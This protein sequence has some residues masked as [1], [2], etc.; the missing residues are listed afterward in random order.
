MSDEEKVHD[1]DSSA[2]QFRQH[3]QSVTQWKKSYRHPVTQVVLL[4][5]VCF[6]TEG[7]FSGLTGLGA[8]GQAKS[9]TSANA[10]TVVYA[11]AMSIHPGAK[12]FVIAAGAILGICSALSWTAQG[13]LML[14]YPI[15]SQKGRELV[16]LPTD[17]VGQT[18]GRRTQSAGELMWVHRFHLSKSRMTEQPSTGRFSSPRMLRDVASRPHDKPEEN[19]LAGF[20][21]AIKTDP[22]IIILFPMFLASNWH[23]TWQMNDYNGARFDIQARSLNNLIYWVIQIC[24]STLFGWLLDVSIVRRRVRA[25][26]AWATLLAMVMGVHVWAYFYQKGY[27]RESVLLSKVG[28]QDSTYVASAFFYASCAFVGAAWQIISYWILGALSNNPDKLAYFT[29][30]HNSIQ[31]MGAAIAWRLD[32]LEV[33]FMTMLLSTWI[34]LIMGL[35]LAFPVVYWRI[36]DQTKSP[37][38]LVEPPATSRSES[39]QGDLSSQSTVCET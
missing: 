3:T 10:L 26:T 33:P 34:V 37:P 4:G 15:E 12:S 9:T 39:R 38:D 17:C 29:G 18:S 35:V 27:T 5:F 8:A 19:E 21:H 31:A 23:Y 7:S 20:V 28:I 16:N 25:L 6:L 14:A 32:A 13:A 24:S 1:A 22:C 30:L 11:T 36:T 2:A